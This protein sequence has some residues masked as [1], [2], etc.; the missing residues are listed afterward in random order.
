M[1]Y[2]NSILK[3]SFIIFI[4]SSCH[5]GSDI[6]QPPPDSDPCDKGVS[7]RTSSGM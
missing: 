1:K 6:N 4:I 5:K 3:I 2:L 7:P